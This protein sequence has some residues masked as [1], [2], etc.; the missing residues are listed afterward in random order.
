ML[1]FTPQKK[2]RGFTLLEIMIVLSVIMILGALTVPKMMTAIYDVNIRYVASDLSGLLQSCRILAVKQNTF[3]SV[4]AGALAPGQPIY[5][6]DKPTAGYVVGDPLLPIGQAITVWQGP[7]SGAPN[8][9][10][11]LGN[12]N[13]AVNPAANA[14]S[15]SP[16]GLP[17]I[18]ALNACAQTPGQGFVLF[19][20]RAVVAGNIPWA[21]VVVNPSGHIQI[22]TCDSN[23][24]WVQR[25]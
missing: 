19:L 10:V 2:H 14:P 18:G 5:Y 17:C 8:E 21:A 16:R 24:T 23:G 4:Q 20:S 7:G 13:F 15:F 6:I 11:F 3:Y 12:L 9:A 22:W 1:D 25:D